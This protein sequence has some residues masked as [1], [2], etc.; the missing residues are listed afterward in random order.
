MFLCPLTDMEFANRILV[1]RIYGQVLRL[2]P[3][4]VILALLAGGALMGII[5]ALLALPS[6]P[7]CC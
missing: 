3:T 4:A 1:S 7:G 2:P 5:G 6:R